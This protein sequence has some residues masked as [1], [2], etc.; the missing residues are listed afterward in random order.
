MKIEKLVCDRC[1]AEA[2]SEVWE[3]SIALGSSLYYD[4]KSM[5]L[6]QVTIDLCNKCREEFKEWFKNAKEETDNGI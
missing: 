4:N 3:Y 2:T 5:L 1:G 6:H